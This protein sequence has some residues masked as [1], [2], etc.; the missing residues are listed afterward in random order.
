MKNKLKFGTR[1][2]AKYSLNLY[3][4]KCPNNCI[5]CYSNAKNDNELTLKKEILNN[6]FEKRDELT[7]YPTQ[8]DILFSDIDYHVKFLKNFLKSGSNV[9]IVSKP[10]I[11]SIKVLCEELKPYKSQILFRFTIGSS[12]NQILKL[13]ELNAPS[14]EERIESLKF[15]YNNNFK[16]SI[17]CEPMLDDNIQNVIN[18]VSNY[19]TNTIWLGNM[20]FAK[21]RIIKNNSYNKEIKNYIN[22]LSTF[23]NKKH[24]I[25]LYNKYK[26]NNKIEFKESIIKLVN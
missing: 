5:Y 21:D 4:G 22:K 20:N 9:L 16:T 18:D 1:E 7:M 3:T 15:A 12:N 2:W 6:K 17:S 23:Q 8:H 25:E 26:D 10:N 13:F 19:V 14:Y 24:T 11:K